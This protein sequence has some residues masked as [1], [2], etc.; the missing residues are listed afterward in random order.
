MSWQGSQSRKSPVSV[1]E[2]S[3]GGQTEMAALGDQG[4]RVV[5]RVRPG[6]QGGA[7]RG[8][9]ISP[10]GA[11]RGAQVCVRPCQPCRSSAGPLLLELRVVRA[12]SPR[13]PH[14]ESLGPECATTW[15]AVRR[16]VAL[17]SS[18]AGVSCCADGCLPSD[19]RARSES[20]SASCS[21]V[22]WA[23]SMVLIDL[24]FSHW[25]HVTFTNRRE[26][27]REGVEAPAFSARLRISAHDREDSD[28]G[29]GDSLRYSARGE[30]PAPAQT[31]S[32]EP[33]SDG[34]ATPCPA[35]RRW[36][37]WPAPV[38]DTCTRGIGWRKRPTEPPVFGP[39]HGAEYMHARRKDSPSLR[40]WARMGGSRAPLTPPARSRGRRA[41][42]AALPSRRPSAA[43]SA[44][45]GCGGA[46][47]RARWASS[48]RVRLTLMWVGSCALA[49]R[50][51]CSVEYLASFDPVFQLY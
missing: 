7:G 16:R 23:L 20:V 35:G 18:I 14:S 49:A 30:A 31:L 15:P 1:S 39:R 43:K 3:D 28:T 45:F 26:G 17:R 29:D 21:M 27:G 42:S 2:A 12:A 24:P 4:V 11:G 9:Q 37:A 19:G 40:Y 10:G 13:W 48:I 47:R 38:P 22:G 34:G 5:T 41:G 51:P 33:D 36:P 32:G 44:D 8:A 25:T 50:P 46:S 6:A